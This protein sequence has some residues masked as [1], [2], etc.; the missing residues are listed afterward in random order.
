MLYQFRKRLPRKKQR[1]PHYNMG[2]P[3]AS[4]FCCD[5]KYVKLLVG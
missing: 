3:V 5:D 2:K 1:L 4:Q